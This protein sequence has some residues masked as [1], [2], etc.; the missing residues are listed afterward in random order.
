MIFS[1]GRVGSRYSE[2]ECSLKSFLSVVGES[3]DERESRKFKE[4]LDRKVKLSLY[5]KFYKAVEFKL[6]LHGA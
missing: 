1:I 4:G 3:I 2:G 6:N 5:T